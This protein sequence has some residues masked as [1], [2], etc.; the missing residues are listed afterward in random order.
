[1]VFYNSI[2]EKLLTDIS[3]IKKL[4]CRIKLCTIKVMMFY[5]SILYVLTDISLPSKCTCSMFNKKVN[6]VL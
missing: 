3:D 4:I 2:H 6:D 1:M 5:N